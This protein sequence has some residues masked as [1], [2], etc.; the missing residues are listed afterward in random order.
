MVHI[1]YRYCKD[2]L[3]YTSYLMQQQSSPVPY[4]RKIPTQQLSRVGFSNY[5]NVPQYEVRLPFGASPVAK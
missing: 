5:L 1:L 2:Y 4:N 3:Y